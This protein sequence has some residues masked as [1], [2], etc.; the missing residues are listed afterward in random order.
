MMS[1]LWQVRG[2][3]SRQLG[4]SRCGQLPREVPVLACP[5]HHLTCTACHAHNTHRCEIGRHQCRRVLFN[6][7]NLPI[8]YYCKTSYY[9]LVSNSPANC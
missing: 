6:L 7:G 1:H 2:V 5:L 4:C 9:E 8:A 3:I